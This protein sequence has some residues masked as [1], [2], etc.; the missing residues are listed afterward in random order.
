MK[1]SLYTDGY[2]WSIL[3]YFV[4]MDIMSNIMLGAIMKGAFSTIIPCP[5]SDDTTMKTV[6]VNE[7]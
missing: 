5:I 4:V 1:H 2:S 3:G 7:A 6:K